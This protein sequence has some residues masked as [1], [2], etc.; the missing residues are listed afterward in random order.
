MAVILM[1]GSAGR[2]GQM[3]HIRLAHHTLRRTDLRPAPGIAA[4]DVRDAAAVARA[5]EGVDAIVH[6]GGLAGGGSFEEV[7]EVNVQGTENV[8]RAGAPRVIL[9]SSNHATG[10]SSRDDTG[11]DGLPDD[12]PP[13]PDSYYGWSKAAIESLGRLHH[14]RD[15]THVI[16]LRIG[17]CFDRPRVPRDLALWLSPDDAARLVEAALTATGWHLVWGISANP[18]HRWFSTAGARAIGYHPRDDA[19]DWPIPDPD[20]TLPGNHLVGGTMPGRAQ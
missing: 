12:A 13:R 1:T 20:L 15:G 11:P 2:I 16:C 4:L 10:Y 14:D 18:K 5:A 19:A 3:L 6:L 9:A 17:A 7:L 8:L